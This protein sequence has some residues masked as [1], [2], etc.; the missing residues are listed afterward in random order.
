MFFVVSKTIFIFA[1]NFATK[2]IA[3]WE[4]VIKTNQY[5]IEDPFFKRWVAEKR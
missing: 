2:K 3:I 5:E 4:T 1:K